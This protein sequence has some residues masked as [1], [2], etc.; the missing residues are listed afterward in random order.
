MRPRC[1]AVRTLMLATLVLCGA[2]SSAAQNMPFLVEGVD[3]PYAPRSFTR[4]GNIV[5]FAAGASGYGNQ[6]WR[7]DGTASGT[8]LV[9]QFA[10]GSNGALELTNFNGTLF[11][12]ADQTIDHC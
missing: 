4:V 10:P 12:S 6:L 7:T 1:I 9:R 3:P 8:G 11:F 5:Y 2:L